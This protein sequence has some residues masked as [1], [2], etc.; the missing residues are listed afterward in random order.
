MLA[1]ATTLILLL[2]TA[3]TRAQAPRARP[4][5]DDVVRQLFR[6]L[7]AKDWRGAVRLVHP[8]ALASFRAEELRDAAEWHFMP[9]ISD[10]SLSPPVRAYFDSMQAR[11]R[12]SGNL[13]LSM[14][15]G[16]PS[17][18]S[19]AR[20]P[21]DRLL[22]LY[23]QTRDPKPENYDSGIAPRSKRLVL[24]AVIKS[25]TLAYVVYRE[26]LVAPGSTL[27][28]ELY[29]IEVKR[30]HGVWRTMLNRDIGVSSAAMITTSRDSS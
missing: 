14:F 1:R 30:D 15:G 5:P 20:I 4:S 11:L 29:V 24:G 9:M 13:S 27:S 12:K 25:D 17:I 22:A 23:W 7:K 10:S 28:P 6:A 26:T 8:S 21:A 16:V 2:A 18:D 3:S 19:L